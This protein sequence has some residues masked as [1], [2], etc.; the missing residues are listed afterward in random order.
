MGFEPLEDTLPSSKSSSMKHYTYKVTFPGMPWYYWGVHTDNGKPYYGSPE[1]HK[2]IW[3]FYECEVQVL[4]RFANRAEAEKV[5]NR[6]IKLTMDD[7]SCL[8]EHY[9]GH[10]SVGGRLKGIQ[11]QREKGIGLFDPS[12]RCDPSVAGKIG[13]ATAGVK[14]Y[15]MG[16]GIHAPGVARRGGLIGGK[17]SAELGHLQRNARESGLKGGPAAFEKKVGV[18][19]PRYTNSEKYRQD[20][21]K[22]GRK[23]AGTRYWVNAAGK[24]RRQFESPGPDWQQGRNW[25]EG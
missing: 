18:H 6:L 8:N 9:G 25:K 20:R 11:T 23:S 2:G 3:D 13:G 22:G 17:V 15:E 16:V 12:N 14:T 1:T 21:A 19:D 4:E 10:F 7:P 5:E 24:T